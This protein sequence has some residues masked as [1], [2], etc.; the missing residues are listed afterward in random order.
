[1]SRHFT[2]WRCIGYVAALTPLCLIWLSAF[3]VVGNP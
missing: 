1:M 3:G 2:P